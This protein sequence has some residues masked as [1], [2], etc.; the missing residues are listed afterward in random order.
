MR[1]CGEDSQTCLPSPGHIKACHLPQGP[2]IRVDSYIDSD[3][4]LP[5][6]YDPLIAKLIA[7]G[8]NRREA[9]A[10]LQ[11]ALA[12]VH[13]AGIKTNVQFLSSI[14]KTKSFEDGSYT[15]Q[16]LNQKCKYRNY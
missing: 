1:I 15:T 4:T 2:F 9:I 14:L 10:R 11:R 12:E 7:W 13:I 8:R 16:L 3:Y 6:D 5:I